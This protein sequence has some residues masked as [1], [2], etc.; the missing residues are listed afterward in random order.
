M[1]F[2]KQGLKPKGSYRLSSKD[3]SA[4]KDA[5]YTDK[6]EEKKKFDKEFMEGYGKYQSPK[7]RQSMRW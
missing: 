5:F 6:K 7:K 3:A 1:G 2:G 4:L